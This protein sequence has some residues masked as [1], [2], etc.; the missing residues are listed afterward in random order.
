MGGGVGPLL[1]GP[2]DK[3]DKLM[4]SILGSPC[5][6]KIPYGLGAHQMSQL[7]F[8]EATQD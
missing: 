5:L 2:Q 4:G 7:M 1:K 3:D 8:R 6:W